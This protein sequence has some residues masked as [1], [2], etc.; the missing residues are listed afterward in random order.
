MPCTAAKGAAAPPALPVQEPGTAVAAPVQSAAECTSGIE[1]YIPPSASQWAAAEAARYYA[2]EQAGALIQQALQDG[3]AN[4]HS[5][6]PPESPWDA[7]AARLGDA[8]AAV[9]RAPAGLGLGLSLHS[10]LA[11]GQVAGAA[12]GGA[13]GLVAE[14]AAPA[15]SVPGSGPAPQ[16][17]ASQAAAAAAAP[18][19]SEK[20]VDACIDAVEDVEVCS[21]LQRGRDVGSIP[22]STGPV[23]LVGD[24]AA[25]GES[26]EGATS[27]GMR[28]RSAERDAEAA[29]AADG[30]VVGAPEQALSPDH[31]A[32][33][34]AAAGPWGSAGQWPAKRR[35]IAGGTLGTLV[36]WAWR[37]VCPAAHCRT[38]E[39]GAAGAPGSAPGGGAT[40]EE[41]QLAPPDG[42]LGRA[43]PGK[44]PPSSSALSAG[45]GQHAEG[46]ADAPALYC[47]PPAGE[48]RG[49]HSG[50]PGPEPHDEERGNAELGRDWLCTGTRG[51]HSASAEQQ[52]PASAHEQGLPTC[53]ERRALSGSPEPKDSSRWFRTHEPR[54]P[55]A[56]T[57][58]QAAAGAHAPAAQQRSALCGSLSSQPRAD[59]HVVDDA[60]GDGMRSVSPELQAPTGAREVQGWGAPS[61]D[62]RSLSSPSPSPE[63]RV[64]EVSDQGGAA[65]RSRA[66]RV[67]TRSIRSASP[68]PRGGAAAR[69]L[70]AVSADGARGGGS[71]SCRCAGL[72]DIRAGLHYFRS[73]I[74]FSKVMSASLRLSLQE[75]GA[76]Y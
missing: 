16:A 63:P 33:A 7:P 38:L 71:L 76:C 41:L 36:A 15:G 43:A 20:E 17:P 25:P 53:E 13:A 45:Q 31:A 22:G 27:S 51:I 72:Y 49:K 23:G 5:P 29:P 32:L 26:C 10:Q 75:L 73:D 48:E 6:S 62:E 64:E 57:I 50:S 47:S 37:T 65:T 59:E 35:R 1:Q 46:S 2:F 8:G 18:H 60:N 14:G 11:A 70:S 42:I 19:S 58:L 74:A 9:G 39:P 54:N 40:A 52:A 66:R 44:P 56:I 68:W 34:A 28:K 3:N 21:G 55:S 4:G 30:Q 69:A 24:A 12:G 61:D 67:R